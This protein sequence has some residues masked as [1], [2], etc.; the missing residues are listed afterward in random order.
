MG[1]PK[2]RGAWLIRSATEWNLYLSSL[3]E[4]LD[5]VGGGGDDIPT[6]QEAVVDYLPESMQDLWAIGNVIFGPKVHRRP[7]SLISR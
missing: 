7:L 2:A 4:S 1:K 6:L 5:H 3:L